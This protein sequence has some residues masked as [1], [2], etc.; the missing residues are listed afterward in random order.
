MLEKRRIGDRQ[1]YD[2]RMLGGVEFVEEVLNKVEEE[3]KTGNKIKGEEELIKRLAQY[4]EVGENEIVNTRMKKVREARQMFIYLGYR[5]LGKTM[6][7]LGKYLGI[8]QTAAS[9]AMCVGR[10]IEAQK[11][12]F[13]LIA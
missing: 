9:K 8:C 5:Q 4:Y 12:I 3:E 6:T 13:K 1:L 11:K 2:E 7:E 10:E